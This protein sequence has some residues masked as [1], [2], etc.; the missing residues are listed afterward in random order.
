MVLPTY[1]G[2]QYVEQQIQS[3]L[4]QDYL[5]LDIIVRDD[6]STDSTLTILRTLAQEYGEGPKR[7]ILLEDDLGNLNVPD[8][9]YAIIKR[10]PGYDYYAFC[11]QDDIWLPFKVSR[12]VAALQCGGVQTPTVYFSSFDYCDERGVFIRHAP[13]QPLVVPLDRTLYYTPGLGFTIVFNKLACQQFI[14]NVKLG[15]EMHDRWILRCGAFLGKLIYD[16]KATAKHL[17]HE[18]A[19]T[20]ADRGWL[21]L[22]KGF[23]VNELNGSE[24]LKE[25][26]NLQYFFETFQDSL[27]QTQRDLLA[28]FC[29]DGHRF[30]KLFYPHRLRST[31]GG[32]CALRILFLLNRI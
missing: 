4:D 7:V 26:A 12:A 14:L 28:R 8:S 23:F 17:R 10:S 15:K 32:D 5:A 27:T 30:R 6:G 19:V 3:L 29:C 25:K 16:P 1:N 18:E 2:S 13:A 22:V 9:F 20:A 31:F 11:D 21:D 24:P